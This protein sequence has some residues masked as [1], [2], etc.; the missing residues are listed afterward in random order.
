MGRVTAPL[1]V[2]AGGAFIHQLAGDTVA[3][4]GAAEE[5]PLDMLDLWRAWGDRRWIDGSMDPAAIEPAGLYRITV[6]ALLVMVDPP[7][8]PTTLYFE[9]PGLGLTGHAVEYTISADRLRVPWSVQ[10]VDNHFN[11]VP[12]VNFKLATDAEPG[13]SYSLDVLVVLEYLGPA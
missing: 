1:P 13:L 4:A 7:A 8:A 6:D 2:V 10:R 5:Y 3:L 12:T 9:G 11:I